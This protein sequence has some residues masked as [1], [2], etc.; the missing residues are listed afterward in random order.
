MQ[1][2]R[3]IFYG[4]Y[5][6][7]GAFIAL[8]MAFGV[9]FSI[10]VFFKPILEEFQVSR[11]GLSLA[12]SLNMLMYGLAQPLWGYLL[13][14]YGPR[15]VIGLSAVAMALGMALFGMV[16]SLWQ[17]Y[18]I[19]GI[20]LSLGFGGVAFVTAAALIARWFVKRR[21]L[22]LGIAFSGSSLG[23]FALIPLATYLFLAT[24]WR[25]T[26]V[27]LGGIIFI[28]IVPL[29]LWVLKGDPCQVGTGPDGEPGISPAHS[30]EREA[31]KKNDT[32]PKEAFLT[33]PFWQLAS[34]YFIC[35]FTTVLVVTHLV[36]YATDIGHSTITAATALALSGGV[37]FLGI[38]IAGGISDKVGRARPLALTYFVRGLSFL[39]LMRAENIA[40]LYIFAVVFGM[41]FFAT[42][43]L[44]S[45]LVGDIFGPRFM[46]TIYGIV[47][48]SHQIGSAFG[49]FLGGLIFDLTG[50]YN[51]AFLMSLVVAVVAS[52]ISYF[53]REPRNV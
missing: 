3:G 14:R 31:G 33:L 16:R 2:G 38:L 27:I 23:Q 4:W 20:I 50:S 30:S 35:G 37:N 6:L 42:V 34:S 28:S 39:L 12:I 51:Y 25:A 43:P 26:Q 46:G 52:L 18:L 49:S 41:S 11:A 7:A 21:G 47:S 44:T 32:A 13:D 17:L 45:A 9:R 53:I 1:K 15:M 24:G 10:G 40:A 48:L 8:F 5:V 22:A 36:A 19:Y 29:A